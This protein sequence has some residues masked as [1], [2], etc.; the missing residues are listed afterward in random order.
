MFDKLKTSFEAKSAVA[1]NVDE[2]KAMLA[3]LDKSQAVISFTPEGKILT[4]ND[5]FLAAIGYSLSEIVGQHH[6]MFVETEYGKSKEYQ[7]F[8][9][10]LKRGVFQAKE[11]KRITKS[12]AEIWIQASYNPIKDRNGR[13]VK[14]VKYATDITARVMQSADHEGQ[15]NA[16]SKAQ[17]VIAFNLDGTI[18]E[19]NENFLGAVGYTL[20]EVK[21]QHHRMFVEAEY[22][23]SE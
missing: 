8:W 15:I 7:E 4:A 1:S 22:G 2:M 17:A 20:E 23:A 19:A 3:A 9:D 13:V 5:N 14:V 16:I 18:R 12:G 6:R 11:F 21:G 10:T